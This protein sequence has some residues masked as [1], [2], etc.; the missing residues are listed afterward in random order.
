M[1]VWAIFK[2]ELASYFLTPLAYIFIIIFPWIKLDQI[3][4]ILLIEFP[5][6]IHI[7]WLLLLFG[8]HY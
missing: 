4:F 7:A 5:P 8:V 6:D 3:L 1:G 2:R